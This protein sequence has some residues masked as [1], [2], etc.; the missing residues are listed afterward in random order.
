MPS[1]VGEPELDFSI[2]IPAF[3]ESYKIERDIRAAA[4]FLSSNGLAGEIIVVDD[5]S[6]DDTAERA[7]ALVP[8]FP[9]LRVFS[10]L[11]NRGKGHAVRYGILRSTGRIVMFVDAGLCVPYRIAKIGIEMINMGMCDIAHGSRG[12][13]GSVKVAQPMYRRLGSR[14]YGFFVKTFMGVPRYITDTQCGFK[15][16]RREVAHALFEPI[17]TDGFMFDTEAVLRALRAPFSILEFPV[18]WSNDP[19]TRYDPVKGTIRNLQELIAMRLRLAGAGGA[20]K[21]EPVTER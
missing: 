16:Y 7:R 5:G 11:P 4:E 6:P 2:V 17:A 18:L 20:P 10:Y 9:M 8:E 3:K 13:R 15:L 14:A 1:A 19:D 12:M 21:R